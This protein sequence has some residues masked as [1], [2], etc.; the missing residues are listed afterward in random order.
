MRDAER[1]VVCVKNKRYAASLELGKVYRT[2]RDRDAQQ[3]R[4]RRVVD[5]SG[6]DYLYPTDWFIDLRLPPAARQALSS[7]SA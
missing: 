2:L 6:K 3:Q 7:I 4:M 1:F 5:E